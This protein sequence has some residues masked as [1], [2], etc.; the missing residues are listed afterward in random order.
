MHYFYMTNMVWKKH[1]LFY[2]A[3]YENIYWLSI[4]INDGFLFT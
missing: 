2:I 4:Y 1:K 3:I